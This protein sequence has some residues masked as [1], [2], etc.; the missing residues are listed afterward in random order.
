MLC[1]F[2][3]SELSENR[4]IY[5]GYILDKNIVILAAS[6]AVTEFLEI[7]ITMSSAS[8]RRCHRQ[9]SVHLHELPDVYHIDFAGVWAV[10]AEHYGAN[11]P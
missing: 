6:S 10:I 8:A 11:S 1:Q 3:C 2:I 7:W 4:W 9:S 5:T